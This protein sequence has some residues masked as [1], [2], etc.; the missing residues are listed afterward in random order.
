VV[1]ALTA[2]PFYGERIISKKRSSPTA[3]MFLEIANLAI[4]NGKPWYSNRQI[5]NETA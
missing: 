2:S 4:K 3:K 1:F 5:G